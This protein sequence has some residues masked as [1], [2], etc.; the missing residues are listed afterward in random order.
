MTPLKFETIGRFSGFRFEDFSEIKVYESKLYE[1]I[2]YEVKLYE[3][4]LY[5]MLLSPRFGTVRK[6]SNQ[7]TRIE[8]ERRGN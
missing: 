7:N 5:E 1:L 3:S 4:K 8:S 2:L 6:N